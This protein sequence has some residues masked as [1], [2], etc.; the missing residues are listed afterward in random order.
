MLVAERK[1]RKS[2]AEDA[3]GGAERSRR[4]RAAE[5]NVEI[6]RV[7]MRVATLGMTS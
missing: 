3:E 2:Y 7:P 1:G 5:V 6:L 4:I